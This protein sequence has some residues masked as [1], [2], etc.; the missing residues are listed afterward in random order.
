M[1]QKI[2]FPTI[3]IFTFSNPTFAQGIGD[4]FSGSG[5]TVYGDN[6]VY[7]N[8]YDADGTASD[9]GFLTDCQVFDK[10]N[11]KCKYQSMVNGEI[12]DSPDSILS[13]SKAGFYYKYEKGQK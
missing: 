6:I 11:W 10:K 4:V 3:F 9:N 7:V 8:I 2:M 1:I 5:E 13:A 12:V